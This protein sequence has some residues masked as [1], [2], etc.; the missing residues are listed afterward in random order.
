MIFF[1]VF[2]AAMYNGFLALSQLPQEAAAYISG[3]GFNPW[4]VMVA[5]LILYLILGCVMDSLSMILLT[6]PIF[7]PIVSAL[8]YGLSPEEFAIWFGIL[9]LI[10]GRGRADNAAGRHE[11]LRHQLDG[12]PDADRPRPI[13]A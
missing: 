13:A 12:A 5:I 4:I 2:G 1:I 3:Q 9:V 8:D 7:F 11:P 10:V 6:I